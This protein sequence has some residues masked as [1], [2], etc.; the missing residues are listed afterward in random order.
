MITAGAVLLLFAVGF[1]FLIFF[2]LHRWSNSSWVEHIHFILGEKLCLIVLWIL[3]HF[4]SAYANLFLRITTPHALI[5]S[6]VL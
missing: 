4:K 2:V 1:P 3:E 6:H 5:C